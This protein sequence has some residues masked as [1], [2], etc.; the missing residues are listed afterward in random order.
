MPLLEKALQECNYELA[1]LVIVYGMLKV[2]PVVDKLLAD[3]RHKQLLKF[4]NKLFLF[5]GK[6]GN[7]PVWPTT[8]GTNITSL[9]LQIHYNKRYV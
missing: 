4:Q 2:I 3:S 9:W 1:A 8:L 6:F 5:E 7:R